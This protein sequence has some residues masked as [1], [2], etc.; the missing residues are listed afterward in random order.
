MRLKVRGAFSVALPPLR[1][2]ITECFHLLQHGLG[3]G[4]N[5]ALVLHHLRHLCIAGG[6]LRRRPLSETATPRSGHRGVLCRWVLEHDDLRRSSAGH[7]QV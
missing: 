1:R 2:D 6:C 3:H 5:R 7:D 4:V